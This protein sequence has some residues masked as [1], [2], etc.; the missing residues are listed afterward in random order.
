VARMV[1]MSGWAASSGLKVLLV[2]VTLRDMADVV[3]GSVQH[4]SRG[5]SGCSR[6]EGL[7]GMRLQGRE[8]VGSGK[9]KIQVR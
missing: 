9:S 8:F 7:N 5:V 2:W 3:K 6:S 4:Q 1:S